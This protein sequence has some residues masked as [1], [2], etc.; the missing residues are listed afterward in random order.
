[1]SIPIN[2]RLVWGVRFLKLSDI[3]Q[4]VDL[5]NQLHTWCVRWPLSW[6]ATLALPVIA[7]KCVHLTGGRAIAAE[8]NLGECPR[9]TGGSA[10]SLVDPGKLP[11]ERDLLRL[12][13]G[14]VVGPVRWN[15][16]SRDEKGKEVNNGSE[17]NH[18]EAS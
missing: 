8:G 11:A 3:R 1:M 12:K 2:W 9:Q 16:R 18:R 17:R 10:G 4:M 13:R 7:A 6:A 14:H 15:W 5:W